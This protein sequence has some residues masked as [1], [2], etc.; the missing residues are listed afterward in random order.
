[1]SGLDR[2]QLAQWVEKQLDDSLAPEAFEQLQQ[3]LMDQP[4]ARELYLDLM[5]QNAHLQLERVHLSATSPLSTAESKEPF[6]RFRSTD[7]KLWLSAFVATA[8]SLLLMVWWV[9][10]SADSKSAPVVAQIVDSSDAQ[11]GD[12]S[13]PTA[14]GSKLSAGRLKID[15][16]LATIRF[17]SG[18]VVTLE[19]PAELEI[20]SPLA[21]HLLAGTAVI[22]VPDSAHGFTL[23]TPTAI[24]IDHGTAFAV[25][26]DTTSQTSSIEVLD[27]EVEVQHVAS[28]ASLSLT[29]KQRVTASVTE[30][31]DSTVSTGE[32]NLLGSKQSVS[33][34]T[35]LHRITTADGGGGD[36]SISRSQDNDVRKNSHSELVLIKN[37]YGGYERFGRKGYFRFDLGSLSEAKIASARFALTLRPSGLGFASKVGDCEFVVYGL[38]DE[39]GDDWSEDE[40]TWQTAPANLDGADDVDVSKVREL[41]RFVVRRGVQHGQFT[42]E[43]DEL[44]Q[45]LNADSNQSV[46]LIVV[47][48]TRES[49]PGGLVHGFTNQ[50]SPVGTP[51]TLFVKTDRLSE[52]N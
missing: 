6:D 32:V 45:F 51:P 26:V 35:K 16:G 4:E 14:V 24:A 21:G 13:L 18:A 9:S 46:T 8:A 30:L 12:C 48:E 3:M 17:A 29:E 25:T 19:S 52:A 28:D 31:S 33:K 23:T 44:V 40:L 15:R 11:W 7:R 50:S 2:E 41:G 49:E 43:G 36:A 39:S 20:E 37:P 38:T 5:H 34:Q 27:G 1:M 22:D 47:R 42:I 10:P